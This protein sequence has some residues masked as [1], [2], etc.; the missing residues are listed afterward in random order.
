VTGRF[1]IPEL[2]PQL[3][4]TALERLSAPRR[5]GRS[6]SGHP[7]EDPTLPGEGP[8]LNYSER[9]GT[10]F[11]EI[12]EHLPTTGHSA[13]GAGVVVHLQY[14]DLLSGLASARMDTGTRISVSE[15]RRLAC[16]AGIVPL[17]L[18]EE[19]QVLDHGRERRLHT[20]AQRRALS[21]RHE[22]CA[23]EGC[24]RPFAWTEIH[25]PTAWSHGGNTDLDNALP[26]C[27]HHHRRAHDPRFTLRILPIGEARYRPRRAR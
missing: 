10:A 9:L 8:T 6:R 17:V 27:G 15:T 11:L 21:A 4:R 13:L 12:L 7:V 23:A 16:T 3:L 24:E 14:A 5:W 25:H 19:S 22:T 20:T 2:H 1:V 18:G 26:L